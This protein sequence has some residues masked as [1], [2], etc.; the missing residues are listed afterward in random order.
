[1]PSTGR[2]SRIDRRRFAPRYGSR[3]TIDGPRGLD[4][5][6]AR[7]SLDVLDLLAAGGR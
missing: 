1:M 5:F 2:R 3:V 4:E 6:H 7:Q